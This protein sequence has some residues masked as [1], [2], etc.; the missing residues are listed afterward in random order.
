MIALLKLMDL[1]VIG[2]GMGQALSSLD[3]VTISLSTLWALVASGI[4]SFG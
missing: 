3:A 2:T 4:C 1:S